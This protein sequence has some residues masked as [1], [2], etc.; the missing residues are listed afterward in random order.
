MW[1]QQYPPKVTFIIY[2]VNNCRWIT[3]H[4]QCAVTLCGYDKGLTRHSNSGEHRAECHSHRFHQVTEELKC[5]FL[6]N[7][8]PW[9]PTSCSR[10]GRPCMTGFFQHTADY[11]RAER[12][13]RLESWEEGGV[14][15]LG[16]RV[17]LSYISWGWADAMQ[18]VN[19]LFLED[20]W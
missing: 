13:S 1:T 3:A 20:P 2:N 8:G 5:L 6:W 10:P 16:F 11:K 12:S 18:D 7:V 4:T 9:L 15:L 14:P 17:L 19:V